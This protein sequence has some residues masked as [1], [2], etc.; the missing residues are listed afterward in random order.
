MPPTLLASFVARASSSGDAA[1]L[2]ELGREGLSSTSYASLCATVRGA[3]AALQA[4]GVVSG[5]AVVDFCDE[6][7]AMVVAML[8]ITMAGAAMVPLDPASPPARLSALVADCG[9]ALALC[10]RARLAS[11][12]SALDGGRCQPLALEDVLVRDASL[13][14]APAP[15]PPG[16]LCHHIYTSGSTGLP[17]AVSVTHGAL[18]SYGREKARTQRVGGASRVLVASAH[19]WDPAVG[20]VPSTL[21]VG[22]HRGVML[23]KEEWTT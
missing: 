22:G 9:A 10:T 20:D 13:P 7:R 12:A 14:A 3:A 6:G 8:A 17:K 23:I 15:P 11:L 5:E 16:A 19:T 21:A 18:A 4:A 1:A 2:A